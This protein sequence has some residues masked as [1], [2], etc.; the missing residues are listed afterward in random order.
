MSKCGWLICA[1]LPFFPGSLECAHAQ[2]RNFPIRAEDVARLRLNG[3]AVSDYFRLADFPAGQTV[4]LR[5]PAGTYT[6]DG[7]GGKAFEDVFK[8]TK[9]YADMD[10][11]RL[12]KEFKA[13]G[14]HEDYDLACTA[15]AAQYMAGGNPY[16][17]HRKLVAG[18]KQNPLN[19]PAWL[20]L[21]EL[22]E[23]KIK[24]A[25]LGPPGF[26]IGKIIDGLNLGERELFGRL[27][28]IGRGNGPARISLNDLNRLDRARD[29][30]F[31]AFET[32]FKGQGMDRST[33]P[34][35]RAYREL[36]EA[37]SE[38]NQSAKKAKRINEDILNK[39]DKRQYPAAFVLLEK[40]LQSSDADFRKA[41]LSNMIHC[42]KKAQPKSD[43]DAAMVEL[44]IS[45]LVEQN[46]L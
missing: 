45:N 36:L 34:Q 44:W 28:G 27:D 22:Y 13:G 46:D 25:A 37:F 3:I 18:L 29:E 43:E 7:T 2:N 30:A 5:L 38:R 15:L 21:E 35:Y 10:F 1:I 11:S 19:L 20:L 9:A 8:Q 41:V 4:R 24:G 31:G 26:R 6:V 23:K 16:A 33:P 12:L 32:G 42:L 40:E 39:V 14:A 17:A